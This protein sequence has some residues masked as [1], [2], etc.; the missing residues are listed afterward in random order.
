VRVRQTRRVSAPSDPRLPTCEVPAGWRATEPTEADVAELVDLLRRHERAARGTSSASTSAVESMLT[1]FGGHVRQHVLVRDDE[2]RARGWAYVHD[3]AAGRVV[4]QVT[5]DPDLDDDGA[6]ALAASLFRWA[7]AR[8]LEIARSRDLA[9]TQLDSGAFSG[10]DRQQRWLT[11]AGLRRARSWWQMSRPVSAGEGEPD[12]L[13][14]PREGVVVRLVASEPD[15]DPDRKPKQDD[16]R[17]VHDVL[18]GAFADHFNSHFETFDEFCHRL[19]SEPGHRWDHW[20][21]AEL[22]D[23]PGR[24]PQPVGALVAEVAPAGAGV[25]DGSYVAYLG[26]LQAARGRGVAKSLLHAVIADAARRGRDRVALEVDADSPTG[27]DALYTAM[28][29]VTRYTTESWHQ[30]LAVPTPLA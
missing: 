7:Q 22:R 25:P 23:D 21:I 13:P 17:T 30:N 26:V 27:A 28:G 19:S 20:W 1:G 10:D 8:A 9:L 6:D 24:D 16:L 11:A 2:D 14:P 15:A 3:R 4:T 18:E 29:F 5:V 12:A